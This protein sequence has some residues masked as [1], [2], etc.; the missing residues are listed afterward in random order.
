MNWVAQSAFIKAIFLWIPLNRMCIKSFFIS[1]V[2]PLTFRHS[3]TLTQTN[4]KNTNS[5]R[6][7]SISSTVFLLTWTMLLSYGTQKNEKQSQECFGQQTLQW[8]WPR[9]T[10]RSGERCL[11]LFPHEDISLLHASGPPESCFRNAFVS[12]HVGPRLLF[13]SNIQQRPR[14]SKIR[15]KTWKTEGKHGEMWLS[16]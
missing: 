5:L 11:V 7:F 14:A 2:S 4:T 15:C 3:P 10:N 6:A 13:K 12:Q 8:A 16:R 1:N 9:K